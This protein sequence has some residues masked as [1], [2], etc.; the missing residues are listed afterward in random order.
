[1]EKE[2]EVTQ[3]EEVTKDQEAEEAAVP[4]EEAQVEEVA[5]EK[6]AAEPTIGESIPSKE[7]TPKKNGKPESI[8]FDVFENMK[9]ELK[10]EIRSLKT[11]DKKSN[12]SIEGLDLGDLA[13]K[14]D[15]SEDFLAD[16][17][18]AIEGKAEV[19]SLEIT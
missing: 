17:A 19:V 5:E 4:Q 15:V 2:Q 8:P 3:P 12:S 11:D 10:E 9:K 1:M 6:V 18:K 7:D 13:S 16:F 14:H